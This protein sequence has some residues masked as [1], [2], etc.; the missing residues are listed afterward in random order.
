MPRACIWDFPT[1]SD[2]LYSYSII[3]DSILISYLNLNWGHLF[4]GFTP[5]VLHYRMF[6]PQYI[7]TIIIPQHIISLLKLESYKLF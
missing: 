5:L 3:P 4:A 7:N 1:F 6:C 2:L